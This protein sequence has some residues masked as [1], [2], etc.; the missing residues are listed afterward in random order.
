MDVWV[1]L[2]GEEERSKY[3]AYNVWCGCIGLWCGYKL[4]D[5]WMRDDAGCVEISVVCG[6]GGNCVY[7]GYHGYRWLGV[8]VVNVDYFGEDGCKDQ[9]LCMK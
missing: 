8:V 5:G 9:V 1:K 4:D 6:G 3:N 2:L 7:E